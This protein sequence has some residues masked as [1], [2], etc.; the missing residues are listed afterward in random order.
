MYVAAVRPL[1]G[2][3]MNTIARAILL[4]LGLLTLS[5]CLDVQLNGPVVRASVTITPLR[6]PDRVLVRG[7]TRD[8]RGVI[9]HVGQD[10]WNGYGPIARMGGHCGYDARH[11]THIKLLHHFLH[12]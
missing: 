7:V 2:E 5:A 8:A 11:Q 12:L 1:F 10:T 9:D 4:L 6:E 3:R